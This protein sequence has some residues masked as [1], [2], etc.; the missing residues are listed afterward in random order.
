MKGPILR[1]VLRRLGAADPRAA[2]SP[3]P[4]PADRCPCRETICTAKPKTRALASRRLSSRQPTSRIARVT[5]LSFVAGSC[6]RTGTR[7]RRASAASLTRMT[8]TVE[9]NRLR[10]TG[11]YAPSGIRT[12]ATTLK[13]WRPGPLVDGGGASQNSRGSKSSFHNG[14]SSQGCDGRVR[15]KDAG[16]PCI[17]AIQGR[18]RTRPRAAQRGPAA[19]RFIVKGALG[20]AG[21]PS[22]RGRSSELTLLR[23]DGLAAGTRS[24]Q[25]MLRR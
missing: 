8:R 25:R 4:P 14:P 24:Q 9:P 7:T 13:G 12:R 15:G 17:R 22:R 11:R 19:Q 5:A 1:G 16:S 21:A 6:A 23:S 10:H 20:H 3:L 18:P 2:C